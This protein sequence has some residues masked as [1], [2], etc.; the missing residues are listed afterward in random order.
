MWIISVSRDKGSSFKVKEREKLGRYF[1]NANLDQCP[2]NGLHSHDARPSGP[3]G[4][5][6]SGTDSDRSPTEI[7]LNSM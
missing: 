1:G 3:V 2:I 4:D 6:A 7:G 5:G